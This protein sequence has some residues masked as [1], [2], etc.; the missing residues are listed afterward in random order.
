MMINV[1]PIPRLASLIPARLVTLAR[2]DTCPAALENQLASLPVGKPMPFRQYAAKDLDCHR[3]LRP[4][5]SNRLTAIDR[6]L[7][8]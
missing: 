6:C 4:E 1:N 7:A 3:L 8:E 5:N 2:A